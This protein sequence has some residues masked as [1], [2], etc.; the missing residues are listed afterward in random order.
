[1]SKHVR[2]ILTVVG[3]LGIGTFA[4][5]GPALAADLTGA[6][7]KSLIWGNSV[8]IETTGS[9]ITGKV[10]QGV[11]YYSGDGTVLYK[12]PLGV[13]WHGKTE[14]KGEHRVHRLERAAE[15]ALLPL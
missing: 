8:Y 15:Y 9:G 12:T 13:M 14:F 4:S 7:I 3:A 2:A 10:G 5:V 6:E 11:I 1:M